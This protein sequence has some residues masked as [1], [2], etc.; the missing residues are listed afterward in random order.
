MD[1]VE[2][3]TVKFIENEALRCSVGVFH[4][5]L[6]V[7]ATE[8]VFLNRMRANSQLRREWLVWG[9]VIGGGIVGN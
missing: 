9:V 3:S 6:V 8:R 1:G 4:H 7:D 2:V 5:A